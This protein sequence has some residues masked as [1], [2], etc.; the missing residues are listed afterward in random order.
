MREKT[1]EKK[2]FDSN[3]RICSPVKMLLMSA[4]EYLTSSI[5]SAANDTVPRWSLLKN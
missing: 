5:V 4:I 1:M 2:A 3:G